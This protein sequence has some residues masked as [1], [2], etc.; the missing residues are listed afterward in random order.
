MNEKDCEFCGKDYAPTDGEL[1]LSFYEE[2]TEAIE[3]FVYISRGNLL[4]ANDYCLTETAINFC[5]M[6]GNKLNEVTE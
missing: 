5:P 6:C 4:V 1:L 2:E 3:G